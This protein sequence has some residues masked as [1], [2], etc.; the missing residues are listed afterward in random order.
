MVHSY[1]EFD[2]INPRSLHRTLLSLYS[3]VGFQEVRTDPSTPN[4]LAEPQ[5]WP[6]T[7]IESQSSICGNSSQVILIPFFTCFLFEP[8]FFFSRQLVYLK[9]CGQSSSWRQQWLIT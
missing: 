9:G 6:W 3:L 8:F 2:Y 5:S 1:R 4:S 7:P